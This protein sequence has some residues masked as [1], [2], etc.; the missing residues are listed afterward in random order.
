MERVDGGW[1]VLMESGV[2]FSRGCRV[3]GSGFQG[4]LIE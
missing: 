1:R 3:L 4:F 2:R